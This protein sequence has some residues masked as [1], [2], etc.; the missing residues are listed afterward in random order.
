MKTRPAQGLARVGALAVLALAI[1]GS[2]VLCLWPK[3]SAETVYPR[4]LAAT[5]E[6]VY[7][8]EVIPTC[9]T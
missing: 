4:Q 5:A 7:R 2:I 3:R 6:G 8:F 1:A 9:T